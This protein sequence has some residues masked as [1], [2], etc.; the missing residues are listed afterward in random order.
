MPPKVS[1]DAGYAAGYETVADRHIGDALWPQIR[2]QSH[3]IGA[4]LADINGA[5]G[6]LIER[7]RR[8]GRCM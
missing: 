2:C 6:G 4:D 3:S 1:P 8:L 5:H 7:R